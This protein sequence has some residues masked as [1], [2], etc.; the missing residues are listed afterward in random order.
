MVNAHF[1]T[2]ALLILLSQVV[3]SEMKKHRLPGLNLPF[4]YTIMPKAEKEYLV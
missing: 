1:Q 2:A 4:W 3:Q